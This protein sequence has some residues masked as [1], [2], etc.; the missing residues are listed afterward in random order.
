MEPGSRHKLS[1]SMI[2]RRLARRGGVVSL[3][4]SYFRGVPGVVHSAR[5]GAIRFVQAGGRTPTASEIVSAMPASRLSITR[6]S[7][8]GGS[9]TVAGPRCS[10]WMASVSRKERRRVQSGSNAFG[11]QAS[12]SSAS[13]G[14]DEI[15][16]ASSRPQAF[17][18]FSRVSPVGETFPDSILETVDA[19]TSARSDSAL[20]E[21]AAACL[22]SLMRVAESMQV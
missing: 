15:S 18:S 1:L 12:A 21:S 19:A 3:L 6:D 20:I 2:S 8:R 7:D 13:R 22:A 10:G 5:R 11:F 9:M 16:D 14:E 17:R 4:A